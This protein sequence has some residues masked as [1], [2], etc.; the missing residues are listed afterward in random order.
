MSW[1]VSSG[2]GETHRTQH[3]P[4]RPCAQTVPDHVDNSP[5]GAS[6]AAASHAG[7][8][9]AEPATAHPLPATV[10]G[11]AGRSQRGICVLAEESPQGHLCFRLQTPEFGLGHELKV[12]PDKDFVKLSSRAT[13]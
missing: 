13:L 4:E 6:A 8:L 9:R 2:F 7:L 11:P 10:L 3:A 5:R 1:P 12:H